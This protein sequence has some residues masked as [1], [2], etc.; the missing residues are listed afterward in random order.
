MKTSTNYRFL[1]ADEYSVARQGVSLI[2][3]EVFFNPNICHCA[4]FEDIFK[5]LKK[6][7]I[8]LLILEINSIVDNGLEIIEQLKLLQKDIK[9]LVLTVCDENIYGTKYLDAGISG[10]LNKGASL[11]EIRKAINLML[12][13]GEDFRQMAKD[14]ITDY[15]VLNKP[16]NPL[17]QLSNRELEV[18]RLLIDGYGNLEITGLMRIKKSTVSTLK[19]R[20]YEKLGIDSLADLMK[21][22]QL[23]F[24]KNNQLQRII[25]IRV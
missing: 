21:F 14:K 6:N 2:I 4:T 8:D 13:S 15:S 1:I 16:I 22:F 19:K 12:L 25:P 9:I 7:R 24:N 20:I 3:K 23:Y 5:E 10:Y 11:V 18:A 17:D